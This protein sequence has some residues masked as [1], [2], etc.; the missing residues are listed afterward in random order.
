MSPATDINKK[1]TDTAEGKVTI[2]SSKTVD[3]V[4]VL[5]TKNKIY[6]L[7]ADKYIVIE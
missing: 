6:K 2:G 1:M 7:W 4:I 5:K 3:Q